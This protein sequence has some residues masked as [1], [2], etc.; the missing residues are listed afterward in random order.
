MPHAS[1][2][3]GTP[4]D[5]T[6]QG[7]TNDTP[8]LEKTASAVA[9]RGRSRPLATRAMARGTAAILRLIDA[10]EQGCGR[11]CSYSY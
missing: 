5:Y 2:K 4:E 9:A 3:V 10:L 8:Q 6:A 1:P 7:R 11:H